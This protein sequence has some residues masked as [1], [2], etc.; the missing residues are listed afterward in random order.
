MVILL[1]F[2][3]IIFSE[4]SG[5]AQNII[6]NG[7]FELGTLTGWT[8]RGYRHPSGTSTGDAY[9]ATPGL[10]IHTNYN[11]NRVYMGTYSG[12]IANDSAWGYEGNTHYATSIEQ[13]ITVP[14]ILPSE[15]IELSFWYAVVAED[16][17]HI[18][19]N[20]P[21]F[22]ITIYDLTIQG[23]ISTKYYYTDQ[24]Y[25][26]IGSP[27]NDVWV[28]R[29]WDYFTCD[30]TG[31]Q[32]HNV[33]FLFKVADCKQSGH[34]C[35]GYIDSAKTIQSPPKINI[36][37]PQDNA[38]ICGTVSIY[39]TATDTKSI[40]TIFLYCGVSPI[41]TITCTG[42]Y[43]SFI[44]PWDTQIY[45]NGTY[46]LRARVYDNDG[47]TGDDIHVVTIMN[48]P[49]I[50]IITPADET[51]V[52]NIVTVT[53][54]AFSASGLKQ[55]EV[56]IGTQTLGT[57]ACV[58]TTSYT[59]LW[60]WDTSPYPDG[61]YTITAVAYDISGIRGEDIHT[62]YVM[63]FPQVNLIT[64]ANGATILGTIIISG[65]A[66]DNSML[67]W[68][69]VY[70]GSTL[71]YGTSC[72]NKF[73]TFSLNCDISQYPDGT[74]TITAIAYDAVG[75]RGVDIHIV[76]IMNP[77]QINIITP[78]NGAILSGTIIISGSATDNSMLG[79]IELYLGTVPVYG[80]SCTDKFA[81]FS[82]SCDISQYPDGTCTIT[83]IVYD[84]VR[85]RGVDIHIVSI[86]N[87]PQINII[88]PANGAILSGTIIILG[89]ATDNSR[90]SWIE[91]YVG[92]VSVYGT[93]CAGKF[94]TF[95]LSC[96]TFR[97]LNGT[98]T[99]T[100]VAYDLYGNKVSDTKQVYVTSGTPYS[101]VFGSISTQTAGAPFC[102]EITV[103][104][105]WGKIVDNYPGPAELNDISQSITPQNTGTF[106]EG[107][108]IGTVTIFKA[109]MTEIVCI[110]TIIAGT[111]NI[112]CVKPD[113]TVCFKFNMIGTQTAGLPFI[114][115][116]T[117]YDFWD[118]VTSEYSDA[119]VINDTTGS[120]IPKHTTRFID[121][122]WSGTVT[123]TKTGTTA[124]TCKHGTITGTSNIFLI[125]PA[126]MEYLVVIP[127]Q[128][129]LKVI[130]S[131][132]LVVYV[133][134]SY[135][136]P[137]P[138]FSCNWSMNP[139]IG[140]FTS[141][142][143]QSTTFIAGT[144]A[145]YGEII[146]TSGKISTMIEVWILPECL[147]HIIIIPKM[148]T[149]TVTGNKDFVATGYDEY[150]N[151]IHEMSYSWEI[152][153]DIG[154][155][156]TL[157]G[158][159]TTFFAGTVTGN[160]WIWCG[161][162]NPSLNKIGTI[163][164]ITVLPDSLF[165]II[166]SPPSKVMK[167]LGTA[168]FFAKGYDSLWNEVSLEGDCWRLTDNSIGSLTTVS[169]TNT[170]FEASTT[171]GSSSL[172][173]EK[174][175][176]RGEAGIVVYSDVVVRLVFDLIPEQRIYPTEENT[177]SFKISITAKDNYGNTVEGY[178][179]TASLSSSWGVLNPT[180]TGEF[181]NSRW[182]STATLTAQRATVT[183]QLVAQSVISENNI[184][185]GDIEFPL[186]YAYDENVKIEEGAVKIEI[187]PFGE[188]EDYYLE[189]T[190][191]SE[192]FDNEL[193]PY[194]K[195]IEGSYYKI[196]AYNINDH[197]MEEVGTNTT[198]IIIKYTD[199]DFNGIVDNTQIKAETLKLYTLNEKEELRGILE[200]SCNPFATEVEG[201]VCHLGKFILIGAI[202]PEIGESKVFVWPNPCNRANGDTRIVFEGLP[203]NTDIRIYD[204]S[205][206]LIRDTAGASGRWEWDLLDNCG[207]N[208]ASDV[209]IYII[210]SEKQ[211]I[212]KGKVA[213]I[214]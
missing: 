96:D 106:N 73:A 15:T 122:I 59:F 92:T 3:I 85:N 74:C 184:I 46:A 116:I 97:Y 17:D 141:T 100:A 107:R 48:P 190:K 172:I 201:V 212:G 115:N 94:A 139:L 35:Y 160:G 162:F 87:P 203:M 166:I 18:L 50:N 13:T 118:N 213:V 7:D 27:N 134:D 12:Q 208:V 124:I 205:G 80:T 164:S 161:T 179:G 167:I 158:S 198:N 200:S 183:V 62:I 149:V 71:V 72:I 189:I 187:A 31:I 174:D 120:I 52:S 197:R 125:C 8:V 5:Y 84:A 105:I 40:S 211:K 192:T 112:F 152:Y 23:T 126:P 29:P 81:T 75:N 95:S 4:I 151:T 57:Q 131:V 10:D 142:N 130:D 16:P 64:P 127:P 63:N 207:R 175:R 128:V 102:I 104:D 86:M 37:T 181:T 32:N 185:K 195:A 91:L 53:T 123:I 11:L 101:F 209:Y 138:K 199:V 144:W 68:I 148:A 69:E 77:P 30:L 147:H 76:S 143:S 78:A 26:Y 204:I 180:R 210:V 45:P 14:T 70:L 42:T 159:K 6:P 34:A 182:E 188:K 99:I 186:L 206:K 33:K 121:G 163:A 173:C 43:T 9:I 60:I 137:I 214:K 114:I 111:S 58:G 177:A 103:L 38:V 108:W 39:G 132:D 79:Q 169:A 194:M 47:N 133:Y 140:T 93:S 154:S 117:A 135:K 19:V 155:L 2:I 1:S 113:A 24:I 82:L 44:F 65:S 157:E 170:T 89:T 98:Y 165:C 202:I 49:Q 176:I 153:G 54:T 136:N 178:S 55:I 90:L 61:T 28:Y 67:G 168:S 193:P 145:T 22:E 156:S 191:C 41:A 66:T 146:V 21:Y 25:W 36:I 150:E 119:A 83:A 88:T 20:K 56:Y 110:D 51:T 129:R 171:I 109:G 196:E